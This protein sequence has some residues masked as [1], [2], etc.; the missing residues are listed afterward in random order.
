MFVVMLT[1][2]QITN[3]VRSNVL[4]SLGTVN[5]MVAIM[6]GCNCKL[7]LKLLSTLKLYCRRC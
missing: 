2:L 7:N 3:R 4:S 6:L 5:K 1:L